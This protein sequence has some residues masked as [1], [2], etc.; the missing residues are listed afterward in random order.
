MPGFLDSCV[1]DLLSVSPQA[2]G[3][4][5]VFGQNVA[6]LILAKKLK[7]IAP[8]TRI[9]FGGNN[10]DG[11]MGVALHKTFPWVDIVVRGEGEIVLP[12]LLS[13]ICANRPIRPQAGICYREN[14]ESVIID[15][16]AKK[17]VSM[18]D[19]PMPDYDEYF[20]QLS[21]SSSYTQ[22]KSRVRILF[23]SARGCWWGEKHHCT[24]CG[25]NGQS[26]KFRSKTAS[27]VAEEI[28][29][30]SA[31]Y[32]QMV[33]QAVDNIIDMAYFKDLLP[34]LRQ[35]RREGLDYTFF[36]ETKSNLRKDH[37]RLLRQAGVLTIQP[38]IESLSSHI[39]KMMR[40]GTTAMQNICLL[41]W[42]RQYGVNVVWNILYGFPREPREEYVRMADVFQSLTH[43]EPPSTGQIVVERFSP[44]HDTPSAFGITNVK[45]SPFYSHIY[46]LD[47]G[48][49]YNLTY[50]F[51]HSNEDG[52]NPLDGFELIK[53]VIDM[54]RE[55]YIRSGNSLTYKQGPGFMIINDRR[56]N[57]EASDYTLGEMESI[58]YRACDAGASLAAIQKSLIKQ[59]FTTITVNEIKEFMDSLL[60]SRLVYEE[61]GRYLSLALPEGEDTESLLDEI[62]AETSRPQQIFTQIIPA[63]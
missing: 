32:Q 35:F 23:E 37:L 20:D 15:T 14:D 12:E 50:D 61:D 51:V 44:Y 33:F 16:D 8:A 53:G 42:A 29:A 6:S 36:Y 11:P 27:Q 52:S 24:F 40:K 1:K 43:L 63:M 3:F 21:K 54:W 62:N 56:S 34:R 49:I 18:D 57:L 48:T 28:Y 39:L 17:Q 60:A 25:L 41:K 22:I 55:A 47:E 46:P 10:C 19:V 26:M 5:C 9:I 7:E 2:V 38:G 31:R 30:L 59:A 4:S 13:D 45:P 58:I